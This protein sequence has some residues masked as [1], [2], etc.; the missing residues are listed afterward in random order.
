MIVVV[1]A[2]HDI[3]YDSGA[4][5]EEMGLKEAFVARDIAQ[6]V[7]T[8][9][10]GAGIQTVFIQS[11]NLNGEHRP[12]PNVVQTA[13]KSGCALFVSIHCNAFNG[14]AMGTETLCYGETG[15]SY[16]AASCIQKQIVDNLE[17]LNRG[18]KIRRD[19]AVLRDTT[20]PAVLVETA[21]IDNKSDALL[22]MYKKDEF[23]AA[24]ARGITDWQQRCLNG[25][26][27]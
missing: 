4:V 18:V 19:L 22:L 26:A 12:L 17:T 20:M 3:I 24:I 2:G 6:R 15:S 16:V 27:F 8:Y 13:N 25:Q 9:L 5:N 21:F 1:N 11:D 23:A 7:C 10:E 14:L